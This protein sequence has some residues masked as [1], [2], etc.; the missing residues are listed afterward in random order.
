MP[1]E[2]VLGLILYYTDGSKTLG[3]TGAKVTCYE[4]PIRSKG[5]CLVLAYYSNY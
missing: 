3:G 4:Q 1:I 2:T 5:T